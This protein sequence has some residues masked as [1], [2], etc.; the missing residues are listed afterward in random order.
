MPSR[1]VVLG[2]TSPLDVSTQLSCTNVMSTDRELVL[3]ENMKK[4]WPMVRI[5]IRRCQQGGIDTRIHSLEVVGPKP[6]FWPILR[7][8]LHVRTSLSYSVQSAVWASEATR[9]NNLDIKQHKIL[10]VPDKL[11]AAI[12]Y[13]QGFADKFLPNSECSTVLGQACRS[14]LSAPL[15]SVLLKKDESDLESKNLLEKLLEAYVDADGREDL[16]FT[17]KMR[18]LCRFLI[19]LDSGISAPASN[20][21]SQSGSKFDHVSSWMKK[22]QPRSGK[23]DGSGSGRAPSPGSYGGHTSNLSKEDSSEDQIDEEVFLHRSHLPL[24]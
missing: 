8:Q 23:S 3:L 21:S 24:V 17:S 16:I 7:R 15:F 9:N 11:I 5:S 14:A 4:Y 20:Q 13:E 22:V 18:K 19:D 12:E 1:I 6:S 10:D 2:G